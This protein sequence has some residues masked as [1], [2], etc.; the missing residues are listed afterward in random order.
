[1]SAAD[2]AKVEG[3]FGFEEQRSAH[4]VVTPEGAVQ[5]VLPAAVLVEVKPYWAGLL[6]IATRTEL[7]SA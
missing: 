7:M 1:M 5:A 2:E 4:A 3:E 6:L